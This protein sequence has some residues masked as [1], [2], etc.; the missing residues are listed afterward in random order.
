MIREMINEDIK[1]YKEGLAE[2][3]VGNRNNLKNS[4]RTLM[5]S[6]KHVTSNCSGQRQYQENRV[7]W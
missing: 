4:K 1:K 6:E 5:I 2:T 3:A 7:L